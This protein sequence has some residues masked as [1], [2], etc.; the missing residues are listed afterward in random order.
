MENKYIPGHGP[1][2]AK[3]MLLAENPT[4]EDLK[5]G[6]SFQSKDWYELDKLLR[7]AGINR[8]NCWQTTISKYFVPP[9]PL[10]G[11]KIP[12]AVR[13]KMAGIDL[14]EQIR[15]LQEEIN[16]VKP[17]VI[18]ALGKAALWVLTGKNSIEQYRGSIMNGMGRKVIPTY[19]PRQLSWNA[20]DVEF[21]GYYNRQIILF[22]LKRARAQSEFPDINLP[23]RT[24]S[25]ARNSFQLHEFRERNRGRIKPAVDIEARGSCL[26]FCIGLAYTPFEG[27]TVPLWNVGE[28]ESVVRIP[29]ADLTSLWILLAEIL[30][31]SDVVGQNFKYDQDKIKRLGFIIRSLASDT[32]L[33]AFAI[34]PELPKGLGFNT[35]LYTEEP[36]YKDEG[37]YEGN[38]K[39]L[40]LGCAR[41]ACVTKEVDMAMDADID[42][43]G[44]RDYYENFILKLHD[45]YLDIESRGFSVDPVARERLI[46]KYVEWDEKIR[47]RLFQLTGDEV[48]VNSPKQI[49]ILLYE[50]F[51]LP[52]KHGT[53]EEE[54]TALLNSASAFK[55]KKEEAIQRET[56]ELILE[57]RRVRKSLGTY[58]MALPDF[59]QKMKTTYFLCNET[60]RT[61]TG[62]QDPPIRPEID[63]VDEHGKKKTRVL[64]LA[65]QTMTKHG[66]IGQD[67]R[68]MYIPTQGLG[69]SIFSKTPEFKRVFIQA[70]SAQAEARVVFLL[71]GDEQ[72]LVDIDA[73]DYHALTASWFF[74]GTE[75]DYSKK[76]L[77]YEH[78]IRFA[79][80]TL[81][82]AGHLGAS[83]RRAAISV[84]TDARKY[85]IALQI[86][87]AIAERALKIFHTKQPR[88]QQVFQ[89]GVV[90]QLE[91][92]RKLVAGVPYGIEA[93]SSVP[94]TFY[95][96]WGDELFRQAYS[97]IPQ[98]SIT[99]NTK[100]AGL[101]LKGEFKELW[102]IMESHDSLL[103]EIDE[104]DVD[105][106]L[107]HV[108]YEM[109]RPI[110]F[111]ACSLPRRDLVIPCE[112]EVGYNY[113]ELN[114][115]RKPIAD[116]TKPPL[117]PSMVPISLEER[118][119]GVVLPQDSQ[120]DRLIYDKQMESLN[121]RFYID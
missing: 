17:N 114:K 96:R 9:S 88:I 106:F 60:G 91:K 26:P 11:K 14:G 51:K 23:P 21:K 10:S 102:I 6:V 71:A 118:F 13:C 3:I 108:K 115:Y 74:G 27:I 72:A 34:N 85:K 65:F 53:G 62:Q 44:I 57:G 76:K 32:M 67:I 110:R 54:I 105:D 30:A 104:V 100:A 66:D 73:R 46:R 15:E 98:R 94:R 24:L 12:F 40:L 38:I 39:D 75:D 107:P 4:Y 90:A 2:G 97:Y 50:N 1:I 109:E 79:G 95:E 49:G 43:L 80:K 61:S 58:L 28:I 87:E 84:N 59:D 99:D 35:S 5:G 42:E 101:R 56:C 16:A 112:I 36:F 83:K 70:D 68:E 111:D 117:I 121:K 113:R 92:N 31:E 81:R 64:G 116:M 103:F 33:K 78:P 47:Y 37:M 45:L 18:I 120:L 93:K 69:L 55:N 52:N 89:A 86:T 19:N 8:Q 48:N 7:D 29:D 41:D 82:H 77:G 119:S 63:T 20:P 22:D 25:I